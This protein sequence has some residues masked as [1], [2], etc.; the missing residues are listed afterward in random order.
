MVFVWQ[1]FRQMTRHTMADVH[2]V[3]RNVPNKKTQL[4]QKEG[5]DAHPQG[6]GRGG[7]ADE[8]HVKTYENR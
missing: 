4:F 3:G 7:R 2:T 1:G 8:N 5:H 6:L